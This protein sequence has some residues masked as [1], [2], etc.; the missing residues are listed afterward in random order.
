MRTLDFAFRVL[1][2]GA[3]FGSLEAPQS[4]AHIRMDDSAQIK[5]TLSGAFGAKVTDADGNA[6]E[7][8]WL[9]DE[10]QP[11]MI[12]D[13]TEHPLGVFLPATVTPREES[14][15]K[16]LQIEAFDRCWRVRDT[17]AESTVYFAAGTAYLDAVEQLLAAAGIGLILKTPS[18]AAFP[19]AREDWQAGTSYLEIVN[20]LLGEIRY[21]PLYFTPEGAAVL[22]PA[23]V[24]SAEN[25][26]HILSDEPEPG[27]DRID[28]MLPSITRETDIYKAPNV[29]VCICSN[30]D[31]SGPLIARAENNNPQ[32]PL[33]IMRRKR[34]IVK[35]TRVN[36]VEDLAA[37][38][39]IAD[40]MRDDSMIGGE[41]IRVST[42][43]LPG[44]GVA[45]V[46]GIR[47]GDLSAVCVEHAWEMD[48]TV[49]GSMRH[50]MEK[51]VV[52]L[53]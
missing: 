44:W 37:L 30:A 40:K 5:T 19:E 3:F 1:R 28:R 23:S 10:I 39:A 2:N 11:V 49:G 17:Y 20:Q 50:T 36:N 46:V 18:A 6:L 52:N 4:A 21:N 12:V 35:V 31:K 26:A 53:E 42:A 27:A 24:P 14:G 13:G 16:T 15:V 51:V 47:Y 41:T 43:L 38:Q 9:S 29:F 22:E 34:R 25:I 33:S 8:D 7:P 45:D 48:L 32:S